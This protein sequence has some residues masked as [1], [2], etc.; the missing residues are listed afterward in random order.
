MASVI[1][2]AISHAVAPRPGR[3]RH[4]IGAQ[5]GWHRFRNACQCAVGHDVV[6]DDVPA[7][8]GS[9]PGGHEW[10]AFDSG[11]RGGSQRQYRQSRE[12]VTRHGRRGLTSCG[13]RVSSLT[14][15]NRDAG[16]RPAASRSVLSYDPGKMPH[17]NVALDTIR[18]V[19]MLLAMLAHRFITQRATTEDDG[20]RALVRPLGPPDRRRPERPKALR[21]IASGEQG[22]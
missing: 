22:A 13:V 2:S 8:C 14:P 10:V 16:P 3:N 5:A 1:Q 6:V 19:A 20:C 18:G 15:F 12:N 17:R 7:L 9:A 11:G 21:L 4:P